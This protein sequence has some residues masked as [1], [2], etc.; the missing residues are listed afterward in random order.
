VYYL[1]QAH[2]PTGNNSYLETEI[3]TFNIRNS[4]IKISAIT[5]PFTGFYFDDSL[6]LVW[7]KLKAAPGGEHT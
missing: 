3:L 6:V 7:K 1:T 5:R 2:L 4:I